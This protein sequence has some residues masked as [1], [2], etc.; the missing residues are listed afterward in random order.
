MSGRSV[1]IA[2]LLTEIRVTHN[3]RLGSAG[4]NF[5]AERKNSFN[6]SFYAVESLLALGRE[7]PAQAVDALARDLEYA[8]MTY[9]AL[10]SAGKQ[11]LF[12]QEYATPEYLA[13]SDLVRWLTYPTELGK[14]P[15]EI[16]YIGKITYLFKK[17]VYH[18]FKYRSGSDTLGDALKDKWL[19]GWSSDSGGTFSNFDEYALYEK[20]TVA[21]TLKKIKKKLIG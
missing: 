19:I 13:K 14:A 4:Y 11:A 3:I 8:Q 20:S 6:I 15:D 5:I 9:T 7:I 17:D 12:P 18:V 1:S 10:A 2:G 16:E 21:A